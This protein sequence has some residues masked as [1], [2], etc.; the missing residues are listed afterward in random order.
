MTEIP[1]NLTNEQIRKLLEKDL[2]KAELKEIARQRSISVGKYTNEEI[3]RRILRN[4]ERQEGYARLS[5]W[6]R[7][8]YNGFINDHNLNSL[9]PLVIRIARLNWKLNSYITDYCL[10]HDINQN[11]PRA[12]IINDHNR[13]SLDPLVIRSARLNWRFDQYIVSSC[14]N[15]DIN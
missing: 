6:K 12:W 8:F 9:D 3:K 1:A 4:L 11:N 2:S 7:G 13:N 15:H 5:R 14:P 10:N